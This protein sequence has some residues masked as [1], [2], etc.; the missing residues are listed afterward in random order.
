MLV[1]E[2]FEKEDVS[3]I[4]VELPEELKADCYCVQ[5]QAPIP[6]SSVFV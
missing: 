5:E 2:E 1:F 3:V 4:V 6:K